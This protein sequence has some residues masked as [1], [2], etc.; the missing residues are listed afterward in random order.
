MQP[1]SDIEIFVRVVESRSFTAAADAL[2]LAKS[3]VSRSVTRLEDSLGVKLLQ[4]T[5]RR[6][7]LTEA[8]QEFFERSRDALSQI[9]EARRAASRH[10][11][12]PSGT[13]R[14]TAPMSFGLELIAPALP[15]FLA[16]H[17]KLV[18]DLAFDDRQRD[19]VAEG[20]DVAVRVTQLA[21]SSLVARRLAPVRMV[22]VASPRYLERRGAPRTPDELRA[23]DCLVYTLRPSPDAWRFDGPGGER[24]LVPVRGSYYANN[25]MALREALVAGHGIALMTTFTV[26]DDIRSGRLVRVLPG[27]AAPELAAHAVYPQRRL[28][29]PKVRAFVDF[30]ADRFGDPPPWDRGLGF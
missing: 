1:L 5:T 15:E 14:A 24:F 2:G 13:L 8:G 21:D 6:L 12:E 28:V 23:H 11:A 4:R 30:L 25:G 27:Y 26:G 22:V 3:G 20:I 29:P 16:K 19:L 17:P 10:Q 18:V 7:S 9:E